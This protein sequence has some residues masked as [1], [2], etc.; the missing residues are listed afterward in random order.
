TL[1]ETAN[2]SLPL[3]P[4]L[5]LLPD[6]RIY[7]DVAGQSF[8]PFGQAY[9]EAFW[10]LGTTFD[11]ATNRWTDLGVPGLTTGA[12]DPGFGFRGST[13]SGANI[14][15]VQAPSLGQPVKQAE[16]Y[17]PIKKT[18]TPVATATQPRTYHNTGM[19]LP[20][21]RVLVGGHAPI[22]TAYLSNI[23]VPG[24]EPNPD[25]DP[26]FE[27]YEPPYLFAE[28]RPTIGAAPDTLGYGSTIRIATPDAASLDSVVLMRNSAITH[29]VDGDQRA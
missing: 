2:R 11:P 24:A 28:H 16:L 3:F 10:N 5:H 29:L 21:G 9:D 4:R 18:W 14:D 1:P 6:G 25:R 27:I 22:S 17:D 19:L 20:D 8:N 13:F 7:Y 12:P 26:S 15:E 23:A